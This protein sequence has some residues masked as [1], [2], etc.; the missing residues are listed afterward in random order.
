[1]LLNSTLEEKAGPSFSFPLLRFLTAHP[2]WFFAENEAMQGNES[3]LFFHVFGDSDFAREVF[4]SLVSLYYCPPYA[5]NVVLEKQPFASQNKDTARSLSYLEKAQHLLTLK[6][7][8]EEASATPLG[9]LDVFFLDMGNPSERS[10][11][12]RALLN[13]HRFDPYRSHFVLFYPDETTEQDT[14]RR[15]AP[16]LARSVFYHVRQ[17]APALNFRQITCQNARLLERGFGLAAPQLGSAPF[18]PSEAL[19]HLSSSS[20]PSWP[21][22]FPVLNVPNKLALLGFSSRKRPE[23]AELIRALLGGV[24]GPIQAFLNDE[25]I[26]SRDLYAALVDLYDLEC[27]LTRLAE[28]EHE[29]WELKSLAHGQERAL[30][31]KL[32]RPF[33]ELVASFWSKKNLSLEE[34]IQN[35]V[36][37][38]DYVSALLLPLML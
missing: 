3:A 33:K 8:G 36:V 30:K 22:L 37:R 25:R 38:Y 31:E 4:S 10:S 15:I 1:M 23:K 35:D 16:S 9:A 17:D 2:I 6:V 27:P 19:M 28:Y 12:E 13:P 7:R 21:N 29:C 34:R 18:K 24:E 20:C 5:L 11:L 14:R 32:Y 26:N